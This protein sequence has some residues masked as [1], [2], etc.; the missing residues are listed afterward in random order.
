MYL[1]DVEGIL[2]GFN[3]GDNSV[4]ANTAYLGI[5][6]WRKATGDREIAQNVEGFSTGDLWM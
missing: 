3:L 2:G 1:Q 4:K 6:K 5:R